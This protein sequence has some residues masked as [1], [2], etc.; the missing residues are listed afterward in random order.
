MTYINVGQGHS[1]LSG[2]KGR[3]RT[4]IILLVFDL[5]FLPKWGRER[6]TP[7]DNFNIIL[8]LLLYIIVRLWEFAGK[9]ESKIIFAPAHYQQEVSGFEWVVLLWGNFILH[10]SCDG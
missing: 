3:S 4:N 7:V 6:M 5:P 9:T 1:R 10:P 2:K 8:L